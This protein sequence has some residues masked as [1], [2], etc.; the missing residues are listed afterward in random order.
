MGHATSEDLSKKILQSIE[1]EGLS[2]ERLLMLA[3]DGPAVNKKVWSNVD[4]EKRKRYSKG[5]LNIG[6]CNIHAVHNAFL[7]GIQE[8]GE[9]CSDMIIAVYHFFSGWTAR[10]ENFSQCQRKV[11]VPQHK[12]VKH[13][14]TRWL[15]IGEAAS[16]LM[17]QWPALTEC[18][19]EFVPKK[20]SLKY[21]MSNAKYLKIVSWLKKQTMK[22]EIE[23]II[24]SAAT[25]TAFT[26]VF[27]RQEPLIHVVHFEL[28]RL[29]TVLLG[30]IVPADDVNL[31][32][33]GGFEGLDSAADVYLQQP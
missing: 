4:S 14:P 27:Q 30:Q 22:A 8:L 28:R 20:N 5:L 7:K 29:C 18:F 1:D 25:F 12:F 24:S 33:L 9:E 21:L 11:K 23:F 16:R 32:I 6:T 31:R 13:V 17:E 10:S 3:S 15:T 19:L 26:G 2:L